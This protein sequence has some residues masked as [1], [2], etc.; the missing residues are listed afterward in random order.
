MFYG[1]I[2]NQKHFDELCELLKAPRKEGCL[3]I[4]GQTDN[5]DL[6]IAPTVLA[7]VTFDDP[8]MQHEIYG[9]ILPIVTVTDI[10]TA[11]P[12]VKKM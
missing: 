1:R 5:T 3:Q 6:Y 10:R 9:P 7:D 2:T 4:G 8:L 12:E 11:C